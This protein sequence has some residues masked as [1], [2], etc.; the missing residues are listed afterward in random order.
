MRHAVSSRQ[1]RTACCSRCCWTAFSTAVSILCARALR[2]VCDW[3]SCRQA[4]RHSYR[5]TCTPLRLTGAA[6]FDAHSVL[7]WILLARHRQ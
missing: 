4:A 7:H 5:R 2:A 1:K 6:M 3:H